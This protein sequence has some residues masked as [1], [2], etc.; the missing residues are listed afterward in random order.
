MTKLT[1][2]TTQNNPGKPPHKVSYYKNI[3]SKRGKDVDLIYIFKSIGG[4][5]DERYNDCSFAVRNTNTAQERDAAK[6]QVPVF[7]PGGTYQGS[8][9]KSGLKEHSGICCIDL[10]QGIMDVKKVQEQ[11]QKDPYCFAIYQSISGSG[12]AFFVKIPRDKDAHVNHYKWICKYLKEKYNLWGSDPQHNYNRL[13]YVSHDPQIYWNVNSKLCDQVLT[14]EQSVSIIAGDTGINPEQFDLDSDEGK[15]ELGKLNKKKK[16]SISFEEGSR[17]EYMIRLCKHLN[18]MGVSLDYAAT[19][20]PRDFEQPD[21]TRKEILTTLSSAYAGFESDHGSEL[22]E[23]KDK[24]KEFLATRQ[25]ENKIEQQV[26]RRKTENSGVLDMIIDAGV[27][28][29]LFTQSLDIGSESL[30]NREYNN[31]FLEA[32]EKYPR[33][34]KGRYDTIMGSNR[35]PEHNP[36]EAFVEKYKNRNPNGA[37]QS[38]SNCIFSDTGYA[39]EGEFDMLFKVDFITKWYVMP[40][41]SKIYH[42]AICP[43]IL[44]VFWCNKVLLDILVPV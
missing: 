33:P 12:F 19:A 14:E 28:Y 8:K 30:D 23:F 44:K 26:A 13:R 20:L 18:G 6:K 11:L 39:E 3:N 21:F 37:L 10:D 24:Q 32:T 42:P 4:K 31:L 38:W 25:E 35:I 2:S 17:N 15:Y 22:Q 29:N 9:S 34:D 41:P 7:I 43:C 36:V 16:S 27:T 1:E 40:M 5:G